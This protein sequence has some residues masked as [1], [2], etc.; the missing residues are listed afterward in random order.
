MRGD[1]TSRICFRSSRCGRSV[2]SRSARSFSSASRWSFSCCRRSARRSPSRHG[3]RP[4]NHAGT[5]TG[6][7][8]YRIFATEQFYV[9]RDRASGICRKVMFSRCSGRWRCA[10]VTRKATKKVGGKSS[11]RTRSWSY[12]QRTLI[13]ETRLLLWARSDCGDCRRGRGVDLHQRISHRIPRRPAESHV[14][15]VAFHTNGP[16]VT[17]CSRQQGVRVYRHGFKP[18]HENI[19]RPLASGLSNRQLSGRLIC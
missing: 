6:R 3:S 17:W 16:R 5:L 8:K 11:S 9:A 2:S 14:N 19:G 12:G 15:R 4:G 18:H 10:Q 13:P 1:R 7:A